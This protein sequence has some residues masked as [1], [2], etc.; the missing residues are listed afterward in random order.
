MIFIFHTTHRCFILLGRNAAGYWC[1]QRQYEA[2]TLALYAIIDFTSCMLEERER[3]SEVYRYI[4]CILLQ[5]N[6]IDHLPPSTNAIARFDDN[7]LLVDRGSFI[8]HHNSRKDCAD[9]HPVVEDGDFPFL[10]P[11]C[12]CVT[13]LHP[14]LKKKKEK[15]DG[16]SSSKG[17]KVS[18]GKSVDCRP[19]LKLQRSSF[20][21]R[22]TLRR[23]GRERRCPVRKAADR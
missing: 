10:C 2:D 3:A 16:E 9:D 7:D 22:R 6:A 1:C 20:R 19:A 13:S 5:S 21:N 8:C 11:V 4:R 15:R 17:L 14:G 18:G 23:E 12:V